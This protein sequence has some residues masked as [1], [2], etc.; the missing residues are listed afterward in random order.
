V[1]CL[2]EARN[3]R[4]REQRT[5]ED[6]LEELKSEGEEAIRLRASYDV[7]FAD[8]LRDVAEIALQPAE[9]DPTPGVQ[10]QARTIDDSARD[11]NLSRSRVTNS[12]AIE[13]FH[14]RSPDDNAGFQV[15]H[16]TALYSP[17]NSD[18]DYAE[19]T[20]DWSQML[21][22]ALVSMSWQTANG[23][24]PDLREFDI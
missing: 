19:D 21:S 22:N 16:L 12:R 7:E 17:A 18:I 2:R 20:G 14:R 5:V 1:R 15:V 13:L 4:N 23:F 11:R 3:E 24:Q 8:W 10:R 9:A 6:V